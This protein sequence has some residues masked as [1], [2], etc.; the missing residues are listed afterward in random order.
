MRR[1]IH[2]RLPLPSVS[3]PYP[4]RRTSVIIPT[5]TFMSGFVSTNPETR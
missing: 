2:R 1:L 4:P 3:H 5:P